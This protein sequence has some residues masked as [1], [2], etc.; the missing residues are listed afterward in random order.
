MLPLAPG[1]PR[2]RTIARRRF[3]REVHWCA[4]IFLPERWD[5]RT[6]RRCHGARKSHRLR[7]WSVLQSPQLDVFEP[8]RRAVVLEAEVPFALVEFVGDIELVPGAVG[9][10]GRAH[11]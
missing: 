4:G 7:R 6:P 5:F 10:I 1:S 11:V 2:G 9:Q 8:T 3:P